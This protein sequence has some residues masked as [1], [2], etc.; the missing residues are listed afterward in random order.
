MYK[1]QRAWCGLQNDGEREESFSV[2]EARV[3]ETRM[4]QLQCA[5]NCRHD[6]AG[7]YS[8][9]HLY[10]LF[11]GTLDA[12]SYT[13]LK[14]VKRAFPLNIIRQIRDLNLTLSPAT[15]LARDVFM[16]SFYTR[17]MSFI[18]MAFLKKKDLQNGI[19]SYRRQKTGQQLSIKWEKPMQEIIDKYDICLLYTSLHPLMV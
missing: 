3:G 4:E 16:F 1:R 10:R 7:A 11:H 9:A 14:T 13:H 6:E 5:L 8:E 2:P 15:D 19:L 18:D 12:V 17:G